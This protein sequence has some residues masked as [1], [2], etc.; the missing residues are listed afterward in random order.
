[1]AA[2]RAEAVS[3]VKDA[4]DHEVEA[5]L[6]R[7][8]VSAQGVLLSALTSGLVLCLVLLFLFIGMQAFTDGAPDAVRAATNS[9]LV[10]AAGVATNLSS[11]SDGERPLR[12]L[13]AAVMDRFAKHEAENRLAFSLDEDVGAL[14][15]RAAGLPA[16]GESA[17]SAPE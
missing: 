5:W 11:R 17:E 10:A 8:G 12:K 4:P 6:A 3:E 1:V 7:F 2:L 14:V 15:G 13:V 16:T 9:L